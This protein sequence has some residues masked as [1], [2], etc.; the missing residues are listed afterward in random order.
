MLTIRK[1]QMRVFENIN[2]HA[3][4]DRAVEYLINR[5]PVRCSEL[6]EEDLQGSVKTAMFKGKEYRFETEETIILYLNLMYLLG[7]E[8]DK[9]EQYAWTN[10]ILT[11]YD[12]SP[13]TRLILLNDKAESI[14][15]NE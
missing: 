2:E 15:P 1:K 11:D 9:R 3:F 14:A 12:L 5:Y 6:S 13:R 10:E 4:I 7:F 8:F